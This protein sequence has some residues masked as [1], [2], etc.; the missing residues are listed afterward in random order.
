MDFLKK[1]Y[2]KIVLG[3]VLIL[4]AV[5]VALLPFFISSEKDKLDQMK[6]QV[7]HPKVTPLTNLDLSTAE[8]AIKRLASPAVID[9]GPPNRL[10]N[11]M[12]WQKAA[13]GHLILRESVGPQRIVVTNI[14]PL[15]L[16]LS[17]DSVTMSD[18]GPKYVIGIEKQAD[19]IASHRTKRQSLCSTNPPTKNETFT[20]VDVKGKPDDPSAIVVQLN[21]TGDKAV[22]TKD[23]PFRRVDGYMADLYYDLEKKPWFRRRVNSGPLSFNGEEYNIVA[24]NQNEVVL[25]AKVNGKKWAIKAT[26]TAAP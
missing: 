3:V 25:S 26:P 5:A 6:S 10:F 22:I 20:M 13:D 18:S 17:L 7:L 12:P 9:F 21:D 11:P 4:L 19:P 24:I 16:V 23:Q 2:E 1:H 8:Q 15:Y 14:T